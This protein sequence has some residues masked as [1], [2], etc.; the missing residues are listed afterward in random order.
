MK[1]I[2]DKSF[3]YVPACS[4]DLHKT[5]ARLRREQAQAALTRQQAAQEG[6]EDNAVVHGIFQPEEGEVRSPEILH[7]NCEYCGAPD[8]ACDCDDGL[9][10][11]YDTRRTCG[12]ELCMC[13]LQTEYG[14]TC[15]NCL[16]GA[17]Q[18]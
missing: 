2:L 3:E 14:E 15:E 9:R 11:E 5:F 13:S 18:G 7:N 17:H 8:G 6:A 4:T 16:S 12:C 10:R 1:S